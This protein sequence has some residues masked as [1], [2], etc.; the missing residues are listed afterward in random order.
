MGRIERLQPEMDGAEGELTCSARKTPDEQRSD[1]PADDILTTLESRRWRY[2]FR[3]LYTDEAPADHERAHDRA[4]DPVIGIRIVRRGSEDPHQNGV[5][6]S[7]SVERPHQRPQK[8]REGRGDH[9]TE[10]RGLLRRDHGRSHEHRTRDPRRHSSESESSSDDEYAKPRCGDERDH[11]RVECPDDLEGTYER[12][13]KC[14]GNRR[15]V[16]QAEIS[17]AAVCEHVIGRDR[18]VRMREEFVPKDPEVPDVG[19]EVSIGVAEQMCP[20]MTGERPCENARQE[21][22]RTDDSDPESSRRQTSKCVCH[23]AWA[24][25]FSQESSI[26]QCTDAK[27]VVR[28]I[29]AQTS[30]VPYSGTVFRRRHARIASA[31]SVPS[32]TTARTTCSTATSVVRACSRRG[33]TPRP[34]AY[35]TPTTT[36]T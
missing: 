8:Q 14:P 29:A 16:V 36:G 33:P 11:D 30:T 1:D 5:S 35:P 23:S 15:I 22:M 9:E 10:V 32:I 3:T 2:G 18:Q 20:E 12:C 17:T 24:F 4:V 28:A 27:P 25:Y 31:Q 21:A 7:S 34:I 6:H 26:G 19:P 13:A